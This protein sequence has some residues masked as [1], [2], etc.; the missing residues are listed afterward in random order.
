M[1]GIGTKVALSLGANMGSENEM[2]DMAVQALERG[3]LAQITCSGTLRTI[4]V[5]CVPGTPDFTNMAVTGFWSGSP[6]SLLDLTQS[7]ETAAGRPAEH[8]SHEA[9]V[10]DIDI[11]LFGKTELATQ[12]LAIPHPRSRQRR[13]V[14][15]PLAE[16]A[17]DMS[18]PDGVTV[19]EALS[20][21]G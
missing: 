14:L 10:L 1:D 9:R 2:L 16:I 6:E 5:D 13:F 4:P 18:F 12:R 21:L 19:L 20:K 15:E 17:G 11:I 7:I 8:S 3:G